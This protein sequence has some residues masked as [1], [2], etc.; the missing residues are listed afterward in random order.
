[1]Q[2]LML[3]FVLWRINY[4]NRVLVELPVVTIAQLQSVMYASAVGFI[5]LVLDVIKIYLYFYSMFHC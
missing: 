5:P 2:H 3:A 1:M 4:C